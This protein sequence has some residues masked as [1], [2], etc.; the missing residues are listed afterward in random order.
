MLNDFAVVGG[1]RRLFYLAKYLHKKNFKVVGFNLSILKN[2]KFNFKIL[3]SLEQVISSSKNIVGPIPFSRDENLINCDCSSNIPIKSFLNCLSKK[4][5]VLAG[6]LSKNIL[7]NLEK[8]VNFVYDY[9]KNENFAVFNAML[10]VEAAIAQ[11][12]LNNANSLQFCNCL[13][14]GFG[15]CGKLLALKLKQ[16]CKNIIVCT[17]NKLELSWAA[18]LGLQILNLDFLESRL[19][20]FNLIVNTIPV[21]VFKGKLLNKLK[22]DVFVF[23]I[24]ANGIDESE[25][26]KA[27]I[28]FAVSLQIPGKFKYKASAKYL[29]DLLIDVL[30]IK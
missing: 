3:N 8:Q 26:E 10:T 22:C 24:T 23:D 2:D 16:F 27:S 15:R 18:A 21:N 12:I 14:L 13:I 7:N 6:N 28:K 20:E 29:A 19:N 11:I 1:D 17:R 30:N 4:N 5:S 25:F 9:F